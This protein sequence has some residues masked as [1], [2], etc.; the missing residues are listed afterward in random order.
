MLR[1]PH[2]IG[3]SFPP[4]LTRLRAKAEIYSGDAYFQE[5]WEDLAV[6]AGPRA[7]ALA[8]RHALLL[9]KPEAFA[10]RRA[11]RTLHWLADRRCRIAGCCSVR[12]GRHAVQA[13]WRYQ[14]NIARRERKAACERLMA[15][16]RSVLLLVAPPASDISAAEWM[17][18][19]KGAARPDQQRP[20]DL[21]SELGVTATQLNFVHSADEAADVV[22]ELAILATPT[23]RRRLMQHADRGADAARRAAQ[24]CAQVEAETPPHHLDAERA[25][26]AICASAP[27]GTPARGVLEATADALRAGA[28]HDWAA[29]E[30]AVPRGARR[31]LR[32]D[33]LVI[34]NHF[35]PP[36]LACANLLVPSLRSIR[37]GDPRAASHGKL[38]EDLPS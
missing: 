1:I 2:A 34:A 37:S 16:G 14:W 9:L 5:G 17:A 26:V 24:L 15:S 38:L 33:L 10:G 23:A 29:L 4:G 20:G 22:R 7:A 3:P 8:L 13:L 25:L 11:E 18:D 6:V 21:R 31:S 27:P 35:A 28:S 12:L 32:W 19:A 30:R 36:D